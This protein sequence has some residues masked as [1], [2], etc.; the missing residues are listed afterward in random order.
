[1]VLCT[2]DSYRYVTYSEGKKNG[3]MQKIILFLV[4]K[5]AFFFFS[6]KYTLFISRVLLFS[7]KL[8][9]GLI[10]I[11]EKVPGKVTSSPFCGGGKKRLDM[12]NE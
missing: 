3:K 6:Q 10:A 9:L 7:H 2:G 8:K 5:K 4:I 12:F 11:T 1:M